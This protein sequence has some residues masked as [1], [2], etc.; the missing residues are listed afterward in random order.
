MDVNIFLAFYGLLVL[1]VV[2]IVGVIHR[3][4]VYWCTSQIVSIDG[5]TT[6]RLDTDEW[7]NDDYEADR[8]KLW[9]VTTFG[10]LGKDRLKA[11]ID[12]A[13]ITR[14][15]LGQ[16]KNRNYWLT[17]SD[18]NGCTY[19]VTKDPL[20][21]EYSK[22]R[23]LTEPASLRTVFRQK[24]VLIPELSV[25]WMFVAVGS[26]LLSIAQYVFMDYDWQFM[27]GGGL[28]VCAYLWS[29]VVVPIYKLE[30]CRY[31]SDYGV[32]PVGLDLLVNSK[33]IDLKK[34]DQNVHFH[35]SL[36]VVTLLGFAIL[37]AGLE[38]HPA[39]GLVTAICLSGLATLFGFAGQ[40]FV[41]ATAGML[42]TALEPKVVDPADDSRVVAHAPVPNKEKGINK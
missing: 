3:A 25:N 34:V 28:L 1:L 18:C 22:K 11:A 17:L 23:V 5:S 8:L 27:V 26:M 21:G 15:L 30:L 31:W 39:V 36:V 20:T 35:R 19:S 16:H 12:N 6:I 42:A 38:G 13:Y 24:A 29:C 32:D 37:L 7:I 10:F 33:A 2:W 4:H 9:L 41:S 40:D 14:E